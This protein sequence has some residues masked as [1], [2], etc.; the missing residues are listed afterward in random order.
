[1]RAVNVLNWLVLIHMCVY[2]VLNLPKIAAV[3]K[4]YRENQVHKK[5]SWDHWYTWKREGEDL[6]SDKLQGIELLYAGLQGR[7]GCDGGGRLMKYF[8]LGWKFC[9]IFQEWS[10]T[11]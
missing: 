8:S 6:F 5:Y 7:G 3:F 10:I 2:S 11:S 9:R 1:M 4:V